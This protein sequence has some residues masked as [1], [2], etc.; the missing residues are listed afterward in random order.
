[1]RGRLKTSDV[2]AVDPL[3]LLFV[4][5]LRP[6]VTDSSRNEHWNAPSFYGSPKIYLLKAYCVSAPCQPS[7][8]SLTEHASEPR[9]SSQ[10]DVYLLPG[11]TPPVPPMAFAQSLECFFPLLPNSYSLVDFMNPYS[12]FKTCFKGEILY[13]TFS[14]FP[15][16]ELLCSPV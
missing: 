6:G 3:M 8:N 13:G 2:P 4:D 10:F 14:L 1:M 12:P 9:S 7:L 15:L 11:H 5:F 16:S